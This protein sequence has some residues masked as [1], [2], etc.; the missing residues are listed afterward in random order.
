MAGKEEGRTVGI[1]LGTTYSCVAAWQHNRVEIIANDQGNRTTPSYVAF[2]DDDERLMGDA[3]K[4]QVAS[5]PTNTVYDAKRL[6]GRRFNDPMVE[7]DMKLWPF[8]V[9]PHPTDSKPMIVVSYKGEEKQFSAEEISSMLLSKMKD[10]AE[11]YLRSPVKNA[12]VTVPAYFNDSQRQAT[13]D[14][15]TIA[16]LNVV[17][18]INEPTAAAI[19]YGLD[20]GGNVAKNVLVFDLGGGTFDVSVATIE[21]D[22]IEVKAI[23]GD[24]HLGG[25][26][27]DSRM[28]DH[29]VKEFERKNGKDISMNPRA[30]RRV[31]SACER[32]KRILSST[33]Q[34]NIEIES[35]FEG[36]DLFSNISRAKFNELNMDLFKKCI[37]L[38]EK[39]LS[40]AK[41]EK[42]S[43]EEVVL[44]GGSSRIPKVQELLKE[45]FDGKEASKSI[46]PD[47]VVAY[48][49]AVVAAKL[50]GEGNGNVQK[51]IIFDVNPLSLGLRI[52]GDV[53]SVFIPRNTPIPTRMVNIHPTTGDNQTSCRFAVFEGE[54][55]KTTVNNLLGE[56]VL[57]GIP[58][59]P[60]GV[61]KV[62]VC[63][64]IDVN[65]I[66]NVSAEHEG[67]GLR[68]EITIA[69]YKG[70]LS[71]KEIE[72]M[73]R[74]G[75]KYKLED[76]EFREKVDAR[77]ALEDYAY[78][79]R[80]AMR[81]EARIGADDK[82][83]IEKA[84]EA[85]T[86]WIKSNKLA[87][88]DAFKEK[89]EELKRIYNHIQAK[90]LLHSMEQVD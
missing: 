74:D 72:K 38:V 32:A 54:R 71:R 6:I 64:D 47:E 50:S 36:I 28:V 82:V 77:T 37:E 52:Y 25:Q 29:F 66:L 69:N 19:A 11:A 23:A 2:T 57:R 31:R 75:K 15:G 68:N 39:C 13:R 79:M 60:R 10:I 30:I 16:S 14:A 5:A 24:T 61:A 21:A 7:S 42:S 35:L 33:S 67:T 62:K 26:D 80:D 53:M 83:E 45:L 1:D 41:V 44:V 63:F 40:D 8:K 78:N 18:I 88:V 4:N 65:G 85:A 89:M 20:N 76:E 59:A 48:G 73:I 55:S 43:V 87:R 86:E 56:F 12:V 34:T 27:F 22:I 81:C 51:L 3:A 17:R 46:N 58:A 84:F 9:I 49:A 70:R 90:M